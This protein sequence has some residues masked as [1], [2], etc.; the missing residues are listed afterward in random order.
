MCA[1]GS[2]LLAAEREALRGDL[3]FRRAGELLEEL[4]GLKS[5]RAQLQEEL[6]VAIRKSECAAA[7][8]DELERQLTK[9]R[10]ARILAESKSSGC[11]ALSAALEEEK[12]ARAIAEH[13]HEQNDL[14]LQEEIKCCDELKSDC[15]GMHKNLLQQ[16]HFLEEA[17]S[18]LARAKAS[19]DFAEQRLQTE[20]IIRQ[21][22]ERHCRELQDELNQLRMHPVIQPKA[23]ENALVLVGPAAS[24]SSATISLPVDAHI[25]WESERDMLLVELRSCREALSEQHSM[26]T[27]L[28]RLV[29]EVRL[30]TIAE[31]EDAF[32]SRLGLLQASVD[33]LLGALDARAHGLLVKMRGQLGACQV[34]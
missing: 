34:R 32:Q 6:A 23:K 12:K 30:S 4:D 17:L 5:A 2:P 21:Q 25:D 14:R 7:R 19:S 1:A 24:P 10:E 27:D 11:D 15:K 33:D 3:W 9:E 22:Q 13:A 20:R 29:E 26:S 28:R 16:Q 18:E 31:A 8:C